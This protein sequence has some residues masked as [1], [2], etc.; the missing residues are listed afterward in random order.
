MKIKDCRIGQRVL[1]DQRTMDYGVRFA[2][3]P[4]ARIVSVG[5]QTVG[6]EFEEPNHEP[7]NILAR[8]LAVA[9]E[10]WGVNDMRSPYA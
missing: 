10:S 9:D 4:C 1:L 3:N 5:K 7:R 2:A 8:C 6:I